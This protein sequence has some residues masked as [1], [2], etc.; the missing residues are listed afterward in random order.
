MNAVQAR[1]KLG[2][3]AEWHLSELSANEWDVAHGKK[4]RL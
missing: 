4:Q 1:G 3:R 2:C